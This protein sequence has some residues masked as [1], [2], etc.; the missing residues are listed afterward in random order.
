[1]IAFSLLLLLIPMR[2]NAAAL[3]TNPMETDTMTIVESALVNTL[4]IRLD[5]IALI[6]RAKL[7][8]IERR[9]LRKE[10]RSIKKQLRAANSGGVYISVGALL[11]V[12]IL[13]ILL[14]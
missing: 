5:E 7:R 13:L 12:I 11:I 8:P 9:E 6:D 10:V 14:L 4:S 3:G 2:S 1:M